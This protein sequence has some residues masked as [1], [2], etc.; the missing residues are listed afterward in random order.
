[1]YIIYQGEK[2]GFNT[3]EDFEG[4]GYKF[5][6][7]FPG[8][9]SSYSLGRG[10]VSLNQIHDYGTL[11]DLD[12]T[13]Y[14]V[15]ADGLFGIPSMDV[16]RSH[17]FRLERVVKAS[18]ADRAVIGLGLRK[19]L[20]NLGFRNGT[21]LNVNG[22]IFYIEDGFKRPFRNANSFARLGFKFSQ[23]LSVSRSQ[24][25]DLPEGQPFQ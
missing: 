9:L 20:G 17:K 6:H 22:G 25:Q 12:G 21:L 14:Q 18:A 1:V 10:I 16:F 2:H 13:I 8:D 15:T 24:L 11:L 5:E 3:R 23:A 4:L 7:V 19:K